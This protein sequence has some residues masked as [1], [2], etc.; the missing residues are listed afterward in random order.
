MNRRTFF[1][2]FRRSEKTDTP[3]ASQKFSR[4][5]LEPFSSTSNDVWDYQKAAHLLR[6]T[7][8]GPTHAEIDTAVREGLNT[9]VE[10]LLTPFGPSL[11]LIEEFAGMEPNTAP[12]EPEGPLYDA[13]VW[14]KLGRRARLVQWWT[15]AMVDSP[16]SVQERMVFFWHDHFP[17]DASKVEFAEFSFVNNQ[18]LRAFSLGNFKDMVK[19]ISKDPAMLTFLDGELNSRFSRN[20]NYARELMELFT[21]GRVDR[22]GNPNYQQSDVIESARAFTGWAKQ[23]S[24]S[25]G[26]TYHSLESTFWLHLWDDGP[27]T[28]LGETGNWNADE[29]I[30][31]LFLK[32]ADQ[33]AWFISEKLYRKFVCLQPDVQVV[34][35]MADLFKRSNWEIAPVL[36]A[37]FGSRHF[38]DREFVGC[39]PKDLFDFYVGLIRGMNLTNIPD[40]FSYADG[41]PYQDLY[42]RLGAYGQLPFSPPNVSGWPKG[43]ALVTSAALTPRLKFA[44]DVANGLVTP[45]HE[46]WLEYLYLFD[47]LTF[48]RSFPNPEDPHSIVNNIALYFLGVHPSS[49]ERALLLDAILDGGVDYEWSLDDPSQRIGLRVRRFL[50]ALFQLPKFQLY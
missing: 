12:P 13:W 11:D 42:L 27:K 46:Q 30:D 47:P 22:D 50:E 41:S 6:R 15:K 17:T 36:R 25:K 43:R 34:E 31:I 35:A 4:S 18:L 8:I 5:P 14:E 1:E 7:L 48:V 37:L 21:T 33:I 44:R 24:K 45:F 20:E 49:E 38:F 23:K 9:T 19:A 16:V 32:R 40:F 3:V 28:F 26:D 2:A 29:I 10:K 39:L